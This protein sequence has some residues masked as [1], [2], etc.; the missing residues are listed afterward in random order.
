MKNTTSYFKS[1]CLGLLLVGLASFAS[2]QTKLSADTTKRY[3]DRLITSKDSA[4]KKILL[5]RIDAL[6]NSDKESDMILTIGYY[7]RLGNAKKIESI[8]QAQLDKFPLGLQARGVASQ[9]LYQIKGAAELDAAY[10]KWVAKFPPEKFDKGGIDDRLAYD[11]VRS[12]IA[13]RYAEEKNVAKAN[14]FANMLEVDFWKGNAYGGLTQAFY[15]TGDLKNAEKYAKL[16]MEN[17]ASYTDGKKGNE[18]YAKFAASGY[19][20]TTS[21]YA[22]ILFEQ[23][24]YAEALKY[25]EL[26]YKNAERLNPQ[27][28]FRYA[29]ILKGL[30]KNQEAYDKLEEVVKAGK[31]TPEMV[32]VFKSLYAKVKGSTAGFDTYASAIRKSYLENLS[33]QLTKDMVNEK[34]ADFTLTDFEGKAVSLSSLKGKIVILDFWA[35][36]CGPCKASFPAMQMAENKFKADPNVK[37]LFIHTWEKTENPLK[38]ASDYIKNMKYDFTVLMDTKDPETKINKVVSSYKVSGIPAKFVID[39]SGNIRFKLTGFDGSNEAAVD[40]LT[41]MIEMA[42]AKS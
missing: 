26:A 18:N 15:K 37:F 41:M 23:K 34:A 2:A 29:Q 28:N 32:D 10:R 27:L 35:T 3:L 30:N 5:A 7:Y 31:A 25:S 22:N 9:A 8:Q 14:E 1:T 42:K 38:D 11:Y 33:K 24:K 39:G 12:G 13:S 16:A 6:S 4:D 36:W 21:T 20:G 40:E 19:A 17:A